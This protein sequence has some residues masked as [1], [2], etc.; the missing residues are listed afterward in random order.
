MKILAKSNSRARKKNDIPQLMLLCSLQIHTRD[1][2]LYLNKQT[3]TI[4]N[5]Y[6]ED[7]RGTRLYG[8]HLFSVVR[9]GGLLENMWSLGLLSTYEL[10]SI[11]KCRQ[12]SL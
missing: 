2:Y 4:D 8:N 3:H 1:P 5:A 12:G 9:V 10:E 6:L 7:P 11:S